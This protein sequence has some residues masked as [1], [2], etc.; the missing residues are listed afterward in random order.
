MF[1]VTPTILCL[2]LKKHIENRR[3]FRRAV[4]MSLKKIFLLIDLRSLIPAPE[5]IWGNLLAIQK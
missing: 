3:E 4:R 5:E 1:A 2:A